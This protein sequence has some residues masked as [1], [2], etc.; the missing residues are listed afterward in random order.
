MR[1]LVS[2]DFICGED[3]CLTWEDVLDGWN[4]GILDAETVIDLA[5]DLLV[6]NDSYP[7]VLRVASLKRDEKWAL[8]SIIGLPACQESN[9]VNQLKCQKALSSKKWLYFQLKNIYVNRENFSDPLA[10]VEDL[11]CQYGHPEALAGLIRWM[12]L[13]P[14]ETPGMPAIFQR[15]EAILRQMASAMNRHRRHTASQ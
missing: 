14:G 9:S 8:D 7:D 11:Y 3:V 12:P 5:A 13:Q 4:L 6:L 1:L 15:W 10:L 2:Y